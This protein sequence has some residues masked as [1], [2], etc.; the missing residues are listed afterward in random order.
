M[1]YREQVDV[2]LDFAARS[3]ERDASIDSRIKKEREEEKKLLAARERLLA[4]IEGM[5]QHGAPLDVLVQRLC[6][7]EESLAQV[8]AKLEELEHAQDEWNESAITRPQLETAF[9]LA[10]EKLLTFDRETS[11]LLCQ[12][13]PRIE[14]VP[15]QQFQ[16]NNVVLRA[17][18]ELQIVNLL[19]KQLSTLLDGKSVDS[20]IADIRRIPMLV[21]LF[22]PSHGPKYGLQALALKKQGL[23]LVEIGRELGISKRSAHTASQYGKAMTEAG[24]TD[25][26]IELTEK[27]AAASRW[28]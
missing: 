11:G 13:I 1:Y 26:Y 2:L 24:I 9:D 16:S 27:P 15:F 6:Q 12:L 3:I 10:A 8:R 25:P 5:D 14:S 18:F 20:E 4:A 22:D 19:P 7:R 21:D 28:R 23:T 17:R